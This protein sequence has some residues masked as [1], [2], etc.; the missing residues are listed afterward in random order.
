MAKEP[1]KKEQATA[2]SSSKS[3]SATPVQT[4]IET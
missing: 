4:T 2:A 3:E 1:E